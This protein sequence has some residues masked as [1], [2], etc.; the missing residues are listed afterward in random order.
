MITY[1]GDHELE[2]PRLEVDFFGHHNVGEGFAEIGDS[3]LDRSK[4]IG[5]CGNRC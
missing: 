2:A 3:R 1:Y 4:H 5:H